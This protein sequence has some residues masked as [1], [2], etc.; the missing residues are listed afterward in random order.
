MSNAQN[1]C[2]HLTHPYGNPHQLCDP[3]IAAGQ[4]HRVDEESSATIISRLVGKMQKHKHCHIKYTLGSYQ[5]WVEDSAQ[6][7]AALRV[8]ESVTVEFIDGPWV[9]RKDSRSQPLWYVPHIGVF[10]EASVRTIRELLGPN[11][12]T[13]VGPTLSFIPVDVSGFKQN[14]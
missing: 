13:G 1:L 10:Y 2:L 7:M 4:H 8:F 11:K 14:G 3:G 9:V 5:H 6:A 12:G